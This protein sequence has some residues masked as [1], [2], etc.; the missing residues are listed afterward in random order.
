MAKIGL[1]Y[2]V[3]KGAVNYGVIGK[4]IQADLSFDL[5]SAKLYA[6]DA[7]AETDN[8]FKGGKI[9][10]GLDELSDTIQQEFLGHS[11]SDGEMTANT[12][13]VAPYV[14]FGF[15]GGKKVAGVQ[16]YRAIW[17]PKVQFGEPADSNKTKGETVEFGTSTIEGN[18]I[19]DASGNWKKE[20]TF[21]LEDDAKAYLNAKAGIPVTASAG[22][23]ALALTGIGGT[24]SPVF[25]TAVRTYSFGG[26]TAVSVTV[27]ATAANHTMNLYADGV[28]LQALLSGT[29]SAAIPMSIG[30]KK[31]TIVA[32]EVGKQ[33]QTTE[34][35]VIK[36]S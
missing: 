14:G 21:A 15:Y 25:G 30:S 31:L 16:K 28:F 9:T 18:V 27:T 7:L 10:L 12:N 13:D 2:P 22:L 4:A 36:I 6:D 32:Q 35:V 29:A 8:S 23:S 3:Y 19:A 34:I 26:V 24:L 5:N 17:I 1:K 20:K 11:I 33:S